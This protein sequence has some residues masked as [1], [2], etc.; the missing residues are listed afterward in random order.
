MNINI[1][2]SKLVEETYS[3][4]ARSP[5]SYLQYTGCRTTSRHVSQNWN[6]P[7]IKRLMTACNGC[8]HTYILIRGNLTVIPMESPGPL[9]HHGL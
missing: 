4:A 7:K 5:L 8:L 2:D 1:L 9:S 3:R 6:G